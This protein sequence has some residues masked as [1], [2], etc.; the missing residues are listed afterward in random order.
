MVATVLVGKAQGSPV[1]SPGFSIFGKAAGVQAR[2]RICATGL[3]TSGLVL[4]DSVVPRSTQEMV[5]RLSRHADSSSDI[6]TLIGCYSQAHF[7]D[8]TRGGTYIGCGVLERG[9]MLDPQLSL[10][11]V[12]R[13]WRPGRIEEPARDPGAL[14]LRRE[15][16]GAGYRHSRAHPQFATAQGGPQTRKAASVSRSPS[17]QEER[18][19]RT[20][21]R[22]TGAQRPMA[23]GVQ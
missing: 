3:W 5:Y 11:Y 18:R 19:V 21:A 9:Q 16:T 10:Q 17:V 4:H 20:G 22:G 8:N 7:P 15:R 6:W 23:R 13:V 1:S 12:L 14:H 2:R